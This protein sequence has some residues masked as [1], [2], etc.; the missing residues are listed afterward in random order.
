MANAALR[1]SGEFL[2][3]RL[4]RGVT[5]TPMANA[6]RLKFLLT[7]LMRGVTR[8]IRMIF[9]PIKFLLTRLMRGV[10]IFSYPSIRQS[11][12]STHTPHARRDKACLTR[13]QAKCISTHTPHA[14]RDSGNSSKSSKSKFLLTRLMRGVTLGTKK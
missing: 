12:I 8:V 5:M 2:L 4:M 3:T 14:R 13:P 6:K 11:R 7:R 1:P 9:F 10:T